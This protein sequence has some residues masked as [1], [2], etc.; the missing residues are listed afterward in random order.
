MNPIRFSR[1]FYLSSALFCALVACDAQTLE[2]QSDQHVGTEVEL[3][4]SR[5]L[6]LT[7]RPP[8]PPRGPQSPSVESPDDDITSPPPPGAPPNR[9]QMRAATNAVEQS[10]T[11]TPEGIAEPVVSRDCDFDDSIEATGP[12][13]VFNDPI[14]LRSPLA[15]R[16]VLSALSMSAGGTGDAVAQD[17]TM[18]SM[19]T[20]FDR[21]GFINAS[22]GIRVPVQRRT[23]EARLDADSFIDDLRPVA[24][25]NRLDLMD[26]AGL[27]CGE[28]R[29]IYSLNPNS[30]VKTNPRDKFTMIFEARYPNPQPQLGA[31][32]CQP[33]ATFWTR[34]AT[35]AATDIER[36]ERLQQFFLHG[37]IVD[38][39]ELP[40]VIDVEHFQGNLGQIRTNQFIGDNWQ[41]R[42]FRAAI[43]D[44]DVHFAPDTVK[45]TVMTEL[46]SDTQS[47][48]LG[49]TSLRTDF[50]ADLLT[51]QLPL[52]LNPEH[53]G[54]E[55]TDDILVSFEPAFPDRFYDFQSDS[56]TNDDNPTVQASADLVAS[57]DTALELGGF[58]GVTSAQV[59]NRIGAMSCG[60]CHE[61]SG[62]Q[63]I[64]SGVTWPSNTP[65]F[66]HVNDN[67]GL[68][69]ALT[70]VFLPKRRRFLLDTFLCTEPGGCEVDADCDGLSIC[71][72]GDCIVR[73][74]PE[75]TTDEDCQAQQVC[76]NGTCS[77]TATTTCE[78]NRE[79]PGGLVCQ[80]G[81]CI[82]SPDPECIVDT[83]CIGDSTCELGTCVSPVTDLSTCEHPTAL[84]N[85][86]RRITGDITASSATESGTCG[87]EGPE[88]LLVLSAPRDSLLCIR[89]ASQD[90]SP[91]LHIRQGVSLGSNHGCTDV[92]V[93]VGCS[94]AIGAR[95]RTQVEF[96][97][98]KDT[99][100]FVFIDAADD[101][102]GRWVLDVRRGACR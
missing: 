2:A 71:Q 81:E 51:N 79:C 8:R 65:A 93:E 54:L 16:V 88:S 94:R 30:A 73:P 1:F 96:S 52:L 58:E 92:D 21:T 41:L 76:S 43:V 66:V 18:N 62:G 32:G 17:I 15:L 80:A 55:T 61:F 50:I 99:P 78:T 9:R 69:N 28:H 39:V 84:I 87:G 102:E 53:T 36:A 22:S 75:C 13:L 82:E 10:A 35:T 70:D 46:F 86:P 38:G 25:F 45:G 42:E 97:A 26:D 14:A 5:A 44:S 19:L 24:V 20:T 23:T 77:E 11:D 33:V 31:A 72:A 7:P 6:Q 68:S 85:R 3:T 64:A 40:P 57:L 49:L 95:N 29:I 89:V 101:S 90:F 34:L 27:D 60:G 59:L 91:I 100:Y 74:S 37:T 98:I 56:E 4:A 48:A 12:A 63:S 67:G 47:D 83:D